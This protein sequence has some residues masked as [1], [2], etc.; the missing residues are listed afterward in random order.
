MKIVGKHDGAMDWTW[1]LLYMII[2]LSWWHQDHFDHHHH[3][4]SEST[5]VVVTSFLMV[6][7][8]PQHHWK[9]RHPSPPEFKSVFA[10]LDVSSSSSSSLSLSASSTF[11][12]NNDDIVV[13]ITEASMQECIHWIHS[14]CDR[15]YLHAVIAT[16]YHFLYR[17]ITSSSSTTTIATTT[18]FGN[19][20][21]LHIDGSCTGNNNIHQP[22]SK[23]TTLQTPSPTIQYD[24]PDLLQIETY[25]VDGVRFFQQ[26]EDLLQN[27]TIRPSIGHLGTTVPK[28]AAM[29]GDYSASI[30]PTSVDIVSD[31]SIPPS[32]RASLDT[33]VPIS[34]AWFRNGGLFYPRQHHD[35]QIQR[36]ML[37]MVNGACPNDDHF[38]I[39][40]P[41]HDSLVDALQYQNGCEIMFTANT[42]LAI[43]SMYD[44]LLRDQLR[45]SFVI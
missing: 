21:G 38:T 33:A 6:V 32:I 1:I 4:S 15:T 3:H 41:T 13:P 34:Y 24:T 28:D 43:P 2:A 18:V 7:P 40:D 22:I 16:D 11:Q 23:S 31:T 27:E 14:Y 30:W 20:P 42:Y 39:N 37:V 45:T 9:Y 26:M 29:W 36:S 25:G 10:F 5:V 44:T 17:G 8:P 12:S 19:T 35:E